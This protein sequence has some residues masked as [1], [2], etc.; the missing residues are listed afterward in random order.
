M[1]QAEELL[2][3]LSEDDVVAYTA[4][5]TT[6]EH[7]IVGDD[8]FIIV[9]EALKRI[10][11]QHDHDIETVTFDCPR[12]WDEHDMSKMKVYINYMRK[13]GAM[14]AY[15]CENVSVDGDDSNIMHFD[16][17]VSRNVTEVKGELSFLVCVK[18]TDDEGIE[19]NH[20]NSELCQD[21]Y[22]SE[23]LECLESIVID[24]PD[25]ITQL[26]ERMDYVETIATPEAMK[27]YVE[28]YYASDTGRAELKEF[29]YAYLAETEPTSEESIQEYVK[30][31]LDNHNPYLIISSEQPSVPCLWFDTSNG[32]S[33]TDLA[34]FR[35]TPNTDK[36]SVYAE[37][38][39]DTYGVENATV[40]EEPKVST[41][42]F[43][44]I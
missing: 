28:T 1:S 37:V 27:E 20:W 32:S 19:T 10:A 17:T 33:N 38:D 26:L 35:L 13:D 4:D 23:G 11:V 22:V 18:T 39:G 6:E 5:P 41:Y 36:T 34:T 16:W 2:D 7:I 25:V 14:G 3:S 29:V 21:M 15:W 43:D 44:I 40:N 8:R 24:Y 12:Y 9:P 31:Y 30:N 42:N